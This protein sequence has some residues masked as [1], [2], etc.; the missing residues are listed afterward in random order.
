MIPPSL[1]AEAPVVS[2][3]KIT[4]GASSSASAAT[5][6]VLSTSSSQA[7]RGS[8]PTSFSTRALASPLAFGMERK[9]EHTS[10]GPTGSRS[11]TKP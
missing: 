8:S 2:T 7:K 9:P 4:Y 10:S 1:P 5:S 11:F 3:S 6:T